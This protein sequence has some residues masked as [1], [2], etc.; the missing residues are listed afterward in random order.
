MTK[1]GRTGSPE[2]IGHGGAGV[3]V[4]NNSLAAAHVALAAGVD[5]IECDVR[6][7][8]DGLLVLVH[9]HQLPNGD[10]RGTEVASLLLAEL[11]HLIPDLLLLDDLIEEVGGRV[12]LMLDVKQSGYEQ[13]LIAAIRRHDLAGASSV[14]TTFGITLLRLRGAFPTMRLGLSTGHWAGGARSNAGR[15]GARWV[16]RG[17]VPLVLPPALIATRATE[18]MLHHLVATRPIVGA[19]HAIGRRVNVWTVDEEDD[20]CRVLRLGVDGVISNRP[21]L[22]RKLTR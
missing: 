21:D 16:L 18:V 12:P 5:R 7:S 6:R 13:E 17:A 20:I 11:R 8:R 9:D 19:V 4:R 10:G 22:V 2:I 1:R 14:S 15:I 3:S